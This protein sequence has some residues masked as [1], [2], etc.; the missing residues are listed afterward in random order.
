M[1]PLLFSVGLVHSRW[2]SDWALAQCG[3]FRSQR[4][5]ICPA[6]FYNLMPLARILGKD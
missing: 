1:L 2:D 6:Q 3:G 5:D 4:F